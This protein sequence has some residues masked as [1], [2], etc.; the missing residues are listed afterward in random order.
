MG[1]RIGESASYYARKYSLT[2]KRE[3]SQLDTS[4]SMRCGEAWIIAEEAGRIL[5]ENYGAS[6]VFVFGSVAKSSAFT[7]WSDIDLAAWGIPDEKF[8]AAV[9][10]VTGLTDDFK[11]DLVDITGCKDLIR[12]AIETEGIEI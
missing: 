5:K 3:V 4:L 8:Y 1:A 2:F 10:A 9:G 6:K 12:N 11:I 7:H